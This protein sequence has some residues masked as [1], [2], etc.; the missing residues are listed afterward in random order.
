MTPLRRNGGAGLSFRGH[1]LKTMTARRYA[2]G[3]KCNG[4][5]PFSGMSWQRNYWERIVRD[6]SDIPVIVLQRHIGLVNIG[7][8]VIISKLQPLPA[9]AGDLNHRAFRQYAALAAV[10]IRFGSNVEPR[11]A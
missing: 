8:P 9:P 10:L 6:E 2:D 3:V 7:R 11:S 1:R 5:A 4:L